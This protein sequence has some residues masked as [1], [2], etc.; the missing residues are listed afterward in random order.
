MLRRPCWRRGGERE[1]AARAEFAELQTDLLR[2]L[3]RSD[4]HERAEAR[5]DPF[6]REVRRQAERA[7]ARP[8]D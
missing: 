5:E 6:V 7:R 3:R 4:G 2:E 1:R 8:G